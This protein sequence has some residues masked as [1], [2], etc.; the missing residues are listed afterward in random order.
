MFKVS[1]LV[2]LALAL[3][4]LV[5]VNVAHANPAVPRITNVSV[6]GEQVTLGWAASALKSKEFFEIEFTNIKTLAK[7]KSIKTK[8]KSIV[9]DLDPFT[10][11]QVRIRK[12]QTSKSWTKLKSFTTSSLPVSDLEARNINYT[13]FDLNWTA[14]PGALSY[15]IFSDG[16]LIGSTRN[17]TFSQTNLKPGLSQSFFVV[18]K[19][20]SAS[21]QSSGILR[22]STLSIGPAKINATSTTST[23]TSIS[24]APVAGADSYNIYANKKFLANTKSS[25]FVVTGLLPGTAVTYYVTALFGSAETNISESLAV[26]TLVET[27]QSPVLSSITSNSVAAT[28]IL[29]KNATSYKVTVFDA[30]GTS[31]IQTVNVNGSLNTVSIS[32][33]NTLTT[34]TVGIENIYES[35]ASKISPLV[36]FTTLKP[37]LTNVVTS[38]VTTTSATLNWYPLSGALNYEVYRDGVLIPQATS[39]M[40][41]ASTAYTFT[42]LT[43]G[44]THK[45]GVRASYLDGSKTTQFTDLVE[46]N[47]AMLPDPAFAPVNIPTSSPV[48]PTVTLPYATVPIVGATL[49]ATNGFWS[50]A[51]PISSYTYQWQRSLDGGT[52]WANLIG[53]TRSTYKVTAL[54]YGFRLRVRVTA[55]NPNG[56]T[57]ANSATS[58]A[59]AETYNVQI[60]IVRGILVSGQLLEVTDGTWSSDYPLT[61]RYQWKRDGVAIS[62]QISPSYTLTDTD[63]NSTISV[64]VIASST[65]GSVSADST[66]RSAVAAA[67]NTVAPA[68]SGNVRV[69]NVLTTSS[70]TWLQSPVLTYQWQRSTDGALWNN[71]AGATGENYTVTVGDIG[72]FI[73]SQVFGTKTVSSTTYRYTAP[74]LPT[75]VVPAPTAISTSAPVVSG[76][77]TEGST[78]TTTNGSWTSSGN[79]TYQWQRSA[80]NS[81]W[82]NISGATSRT[83]VLV[84]ADALKYVRVQVYISSSSGVDGVAFSVPTAKVGAPYNT[85]APA[86]SG[87]IRVGLVQTVSTGTWSGSPSYAYQWQTSSDGIAWA[88]ISGA[89]NST[90]TPTY[91]IANLRLRAVVSAGNAVETVTATSQ[92]VQGFLPPI[93]SDVPVIS[94]T[95]QAAATL[96]TSSGTWSG[97]PDA[98][99]YSWHRSSDG[100]VTW[101]N[102]AGATAATYVVAAGDV[103]YRIRSQ[104]TVSTNAGSSTAYSLPTA[105][106]AP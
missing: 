75:V 17:T 1:K 106:V 38:S 73:R 35:T 15:D 64:S 11:Y 63:I 85:V 19:S 101:V 50:S 13:S 29:D 68:I 89:T 30:N 28:W 46:I 61:F 33:L 34:Y 2:V 31:A 98:F 92:V 36:S 88:N 67:G 48:L 103:G 56:S 8:A 90:Y 37:T 55:T 21:G 87:T 59:V 65:L 71:I 95:V 99:T 54:D 96:T 69:Y 77:W 14:V 97:S 3:Q 7:I 53:E 4:S 32:G 27:P 6:N 24:W 74:S 84:A 93:A 82:E 22:V 105:P 9:A 12:N 43:P 79:F 44:N 70:G 40:T 49:T 62:G 60:P 72:F 76:S 81:T 26:N 66:I 102:I 91:A 51:T 18:P 58:S 25:S 78:L 57:T 23:G 45:L 94:G 16:K 10:T 42:G 86:V 41:S 5:Q 83:Y 100:G 104:V 80:D 47:Q 20:G 52:T 39:L